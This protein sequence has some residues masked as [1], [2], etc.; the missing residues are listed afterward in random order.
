MS[1]SE[2]DPAGA[3][4]KRPV[5]VMAEQKPHSVV[6]CLT[7]IAQHHGL[8]VNPERLIEE[9]ALSDEEPRPALVIRMAA[10]IGLKGKL[11][12]LTW[13]GLFLSLIHI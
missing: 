1:G 13:K 11:T 12:K 3:S 10:G 9:H 4:L 5:F 2:L 7:A 8:Q 6:Q